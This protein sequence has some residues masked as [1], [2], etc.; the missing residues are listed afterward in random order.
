MGCA[1]DVDDE[2][3]RQNRHTHTLSHTQ[4]L[5]SL[6]QQ[7]SRLQGKLSV[8]RLSRLGQTAL[9]SQSLLMLTPRRSDSRIRKSPQVVDEQTSDNGFQVG[10]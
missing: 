1:E 5:K 6:G 10:R 8:A 3:R 2:V 7:I 9:V 4:R